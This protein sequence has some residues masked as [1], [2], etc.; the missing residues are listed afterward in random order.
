MFVIVHGF[1]LVISYF[2]LEGCS[3]MSWL[4]LFHPSLPSFSHQFVCVCCPSCSCPISL[5][6]NGLSF[7]GVL[8]HSF[9]MPLLF[10]LPASLTV[11]FQLYDIKVHF[12]FFLLAWCFFIEL[13]RFQILF[14]LPRPES[15][16]LYLR[17]VEKLFSI[18]M[19]PK[20]FSFL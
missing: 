18:L 10:F 7:D 3:P 6:L 17:A 15:N 11:L 9:W 20:V 14:L 13:L 19:S 12:F 5:H 1:S 16:N 4:R 2:Y 8:L